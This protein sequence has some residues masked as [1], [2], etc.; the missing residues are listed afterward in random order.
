MIIHVLVALAVVYALACGFVFL[1]QRGLLYFPT[2]GRG[3]SVITLPID[4]ERVLVSSRPVDG[5]DAILYFGGNAEDVTFNMPVFLRLFPKHALYLL[6]YRG[7]NGSSGSPWERALVIDAFALYDYVKAIHPKINLIGRS[8]GSGLAVRVASER[9]VAALILVT[10][11]DSMQ[12]IAASHFPLFPVRWL[13]RD[14]YESWKYA[15][16]VKAPVT[17]IAAEHDEI[18]PRASTD[19]LRTRF[20]PDAVTFAVIPRT[21]HNS[22]SE[23]EEYLS[24]LQAGVL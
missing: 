4:N 21:D 10:P 15:P 17:I 11:Y 9:E 13:L 22:I 19:L 24:R 3:E 16:R 23:S 1:A 7:Y 6:H 20:P 14:K 18:I 12:D 2:A 8:L 5:P